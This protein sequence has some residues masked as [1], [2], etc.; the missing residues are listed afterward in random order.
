MTYGESKYFM[1]SGMITN[2]TVAVCL[3]RAKG[4]KTITN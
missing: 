3:I 2:K 4:I 1:T